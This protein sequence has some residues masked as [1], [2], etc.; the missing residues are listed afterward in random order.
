MDTQRGV[1]ELQIVETEP[2]RLLPFPY[3]GGISIRPPRRMAVRPGVSRFSPLTAP[4]SMARMI[5]LQAV[6]CSWCGITFPPRPNCHGIRWRSYFQRWRRSW[7]AN[8]RSSPMKAAP[9]NSAIM[10]SSNSMMDESWESVTIATSG[11]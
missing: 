3:Q 4:E 2:D 7:G 10:G 11:R 8:P 6:T 1:M 5:K 9:I